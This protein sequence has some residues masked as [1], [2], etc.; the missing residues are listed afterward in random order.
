MEQLR[1]QT[2]AT[3]AVEALYERFR[4][5]RKQTEE[6]C[7]PLQ[8]EDYV[9]QP[10]VEVSPPKWH[11]G[12]TSWFFEEFVL[13]PRK[14]GYR[15]FHPD[16]AFLFNSY[17]ESVG[18][19]VMRT[20]RGNL[21]RPS[22]AEVYAYRK[23]VNEQMEEYLLQ[24]E[25]P[26]DIRFVIEM[27]LQH[28]QQHQELLIYDIK[29]ILGGNPLF[30][31][32]KELA[33][34]RPAN[35]PKAANWLE[36]EEGLYTIGCNQ[37]DTFHFDNER[38]A[39]KEYLEAFRL[40]DRLV[41]NGEYIEFMED[42][43]YKDFRHWLQEGWEWVKQEKIQAPFHWHQVEGEW[44]R[45]SLHGLEKLNLQAPMSHIS[46]YEADA[47]ARWKGMRLP[48]EAEWEVACRQYSP[49][50]PGSANLQQSG[51]FEPQPPQSGNYQF[52]GDL[53][54]WTAS[55]YRPYPYYEAPEGALGEYNGKFMIN[56]M[57]LRGGSCATP[58]DHIR[59]SYRNF[60]HPQLRWFFSGLRL[61]QYV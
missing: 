6:I 50:I 47:Y 10:V 16:Y 21:T 58:E 44:Y 49:H 14:E 20:N 52:Y 34:E 43:G 60:F 11:L 48:T 36:V 31:V 53:W 59:P 24:A 8:A 30:P 56:Q 57:V 37:P 28:E 41:T 2:A 55:A 26:D 5:I 12:H 13:K 19:R 42:G 46:F 35:V 15:L 25:L 61:A 38:G 22:V 27:G 17:Y 39:H 40:M 4:R 23:Y 33:M 32:Y 45:Y 1:E 9:V 29:F 3:T 51:V 7:A 54:E 18:R